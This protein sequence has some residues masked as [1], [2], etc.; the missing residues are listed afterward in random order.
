MA[1]INTYEQYLDSEEPYCN[2]ELCFPDQLRRSD[3]QELSDEL[4]ST[5]E[6]WAP[7]NLRRS[8]MHL[9]QSINSKKNQQS[10]CSLNAYHSDVYA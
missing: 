4:L 9:E 3:L 1:T 5:E 2:E 7:R 8:E 10:D 6:L